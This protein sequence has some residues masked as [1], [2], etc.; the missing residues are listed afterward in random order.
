MNYISLL[1][2][3]SFIF[4]LI[5]MSTLPPD[6]AERVTALEASCLQAREDRK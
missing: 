1:A 6:L 4:V 2:I 5:I 3:V